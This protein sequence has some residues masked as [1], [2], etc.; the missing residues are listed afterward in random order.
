M[1]LNIHPCT[2]TQLEGYITELFKN[3]VTHFLSTKNATYLVFFMENFTDKTKEREREINNTANKAKYSRRYTWITK[4]WHTTETTLKKKKDCC[5]LSTLL[6]PSLPIKGNRILHMASTICARNNIKLFDKRQG[7][8][9]CTGGRKLLGS[10]HPPIMIL[11]FP[12]S[13]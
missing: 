13:L 10:P 12:A 9:K 5:A 7:L 8:G 2:Q 6:H 3:T 4:G 11:S 1:K